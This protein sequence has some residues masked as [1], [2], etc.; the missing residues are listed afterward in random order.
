MHAFIL[1]LCYEI[2]LLKGKDLYKEDIYLIF[3][4][5]EISVQEVDINTGFSYHY[6]P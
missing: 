3:I 6:N 1:Q 4:N 2:Q 5:L